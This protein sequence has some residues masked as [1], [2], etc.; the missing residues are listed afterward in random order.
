MQPAQH[1]RAAPHH[2]HD[3]IADILFVTNGFTLVAGVDGHGPPVKM[4]AVGVDIADPAGLLASRYDLRPG[5]AFLLRPDQHVC[6]RWRAVE[7]DA[8]GGAIRRALAFA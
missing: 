3:A 8:I 7:A 2:A 5:T 1:G 4:L 6:A